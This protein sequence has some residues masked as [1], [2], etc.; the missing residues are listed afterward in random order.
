MLN[1]SNSERMG[2]TRRLETMT[3][4]SNVS[5]KDMPSI[6]PTVLPPWMREILTEEEKKKI[7]EQAQVPCYL[8]LPI[9][10]EE[11]DEESDIIEH[12]IVE[13]DI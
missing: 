11:R 8:P 6:Y 7:D 4:K 9:P 5:E 10:K 2:G 3:G 13:I 12:S 1:L